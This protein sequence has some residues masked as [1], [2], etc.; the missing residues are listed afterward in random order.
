MINT[1]L[2]Q[3]TR[4]FHDL[5]TTH[6]MALLPTLFWSCHSEIERPIKYVILKCK[7]TLSWV[8]EGIYSFRKTEFISW[9]AKD[10]KFVVKI[11][12]NF[13]IE[14]ISAI[15][16]QIKRDS[17]SRWHHNDAQQYHRGI[18][19]RV[20][21][22]LSLTQSTNSFVICFC[23]YLLHCGFSHI[24]NNHFYQLASNLFIC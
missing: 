9:R 21:T 1:Q 4:V 16:Y 11:S 15:V 17:P 22:D 10:V 7:H 14:K 18:P 3:S 24:H 20:Q 19:L 6:K 23:S 12:K 13:K 8:F 5:S 2:Y